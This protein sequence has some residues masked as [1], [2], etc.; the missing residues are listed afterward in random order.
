MTQAKIAAEARNEKRLGKAER[1]IIALGIAVA[2]IIMFVGTGGTVLPRVVRVLA[3]NGLPPDLLLTNALLL[4]VALVIFGWRRYREL[5]EEVR[6][7]R[8]AEEQAR[9]LAETD[10]LTGCLNRRSIAPAT[11]ALIADAR[12]QGR[13]VAFIMLDLDKFKQINDIHSHAAGDAVLCEA[14]RR[15]C[16]TLPE[17]SLVARIGGDEFACV[18]PFDPTVPDVIDR[19]VTRLIHCVARPFDHAGIALET[20]IS[21]GL[22]S[23]DR[24]SQQDDSDAFL[25]MA[26]IAMY[27]AKS[28]GRNQYAWFAPAMADDLRF[29]SELESGIRLGLAQG[30]FV[31]FYEKQI[32]LA[33]GRLTGFEMLARWKSPK[34]GLVSPDIFIPIAEEI[35]V[36]SE[37]SE[38]LIRQALRDA[39]GWD[40]QLTLS[41]NISPL[42][43]RDPWFAQRLLK[44]LVEGNFPPSRLEIE[45]TESCLHENLSLVRTLVVSLKNQ[46]VCISLDDFGTG[47]SSLSQLRQLP[48]DRIKIDRSFVSNLPGNKDSATIIQ[49]IVSLSEGL[50]MPVTAEGVENEDVLNALREFGSFKVQGFLYGRPASADQISAEL[51]KAGQPSAED[52]EEAG[53]AQHQA[54]GRG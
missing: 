28:H 33:T 51:A 53:P 29:R 13:A 12:K 5:T 47:Y 39:K 2:A 54:A 37:L 41:V 46:G 40:P 27:H 30:E 24:G 22:S 36:I 26:D 38:Q 18:V 44:L 10:P 15:I 50:G 32:D 21:A 19:L 52:A 7:R 43:L 35:G 9:V 8:N 3:G 23:T 16:A 45:I 42:Q 6:E 4:N 34:L 14:A 11:D 48:F 17:S 25:H 1:D 31:P 49:S 20:T